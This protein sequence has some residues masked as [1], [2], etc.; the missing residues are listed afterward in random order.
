M[1]VG[2][3]LKFKTVKEL[4]DKIQ[5]YFN[6]CFEEQWFDEVMRDEN[7]NIEPLED[8]KKILQPV[9]KRVQIKP[10]TITGLAVALETS[11]QTLIN[12][13]DKDQYFDT[14]KKAKN[15]IESYVEE[16]L[17]NGRNAVG[18]IFNLKNNFEWRD[19]QEIVDQRSYSEL[20]KM[21]EKLNNLTTN[22]K[23]GNSKNT[24]KTKR[25]MPLPA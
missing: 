6:S 4:E 3:P 9:K 8:G 15:F 11:R 7:G 12:Y 18:V 20:E 19:T 24:G 13:E 25:D 10:I 22:A 23:A 21:R 14:I 2:R 1:K 16:Q 17:F 5:G